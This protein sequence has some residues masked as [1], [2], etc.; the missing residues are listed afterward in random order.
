ELIPARLRGRIDIYING[1]YWI[2]AAAG[3]ASTVVLLD[4]T[5]FAVDLG[6]R[7]GFFI[8][9]A[10][11][12]FI[13]FVRRHVPESPR[14]LITHGHPDEAERVVRG[15]EQ[16]AAV[17]KNLPSVDESNAVVLHPRRHFGFGIVLRTIFGRYWRR[18]LVGFSLMVSQAFL[19]NAIFFTYALV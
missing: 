18:S 6:W 14:W 7:V 1:S 19:Y 11:G 10:L 3:A 12:L 9:A 4:P 13:I 17:R 8:S 16:R 5:L 2:G 15:I